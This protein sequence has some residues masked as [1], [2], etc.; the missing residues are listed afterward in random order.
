MRHNI[1]RAMEKGLGIPGAVF[2]GDVLVL[3]LPGI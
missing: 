2:S 3:I 1:G